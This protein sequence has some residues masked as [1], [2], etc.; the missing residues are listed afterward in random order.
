MVVLRVAGSAVKVGSRYVRCWGF[1]AELPEGTFRV[2]GSFRAASGSGVDADWYALGH[3]LRYVN[4]SG[5]LV[6]HV[7]VVVDSGRVYRRLAD[8]A[9]S[10]NPREAGYVGRVK[11]LLVDIGCGWDVL[12]VPRWQNRDARMTAENAVMSV[13]AGG[14]FNERGTRDDVPQ[15]Q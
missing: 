6:R 2:C 3:G 8:Y 1:V 14:F 15:G 4:D 11:Q 10:V 9:A 7:E 12:R 13:G 5:L